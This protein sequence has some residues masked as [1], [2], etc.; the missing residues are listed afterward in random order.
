MNT[1]KFV[2]FT[3]ENK[4]VVEYLL[5]QLILSDSITEA[6]IFDNYDL[7]IGFRKMLVKNCNL[8]CSINTYIE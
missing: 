1:T 8:D 3:A 6:L 4:Y 5:Q 7:A 2:L